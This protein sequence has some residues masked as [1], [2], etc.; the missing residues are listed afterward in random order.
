VICYNSTSN[1]VYC[2]NAGSQNLSVID[3]ATNTVVAT[4]PT[5]NVPRG[6]AF[7][8]QSDLVY[9]SNY[10]SDNVTVI[11]GATNAVVATV[12]VGDG[13]TALFHNPATNTMYCSNVGAPGP[14]TPAACT[15]SVIDATTNTV[16]ATLPAGD[17]PTAFC[18]STNN[19]KVYWVNEWSHTVAVVDAFTNAPITL[20][21]LGTPPVQA[22]DL[23]YNPVNERVYSANRLTYSIGI[24]ADSLLSTGAAE[25]DAA[26]LLVQ[27]YPNPASD[28][29]MI[30]GLVNG[31]LA[32]TVFGAHGA[33]LVQGTTTDRSI[34]VHQLPA[35]LH[36]L[37]LR[38]GSGQRCVE[39]VMV[40]R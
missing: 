23:C 27:L 30:T 10:G 20:I 32:Y 11:D 38:D 12:A 36:A 16:V 35:G 14:G 17:E 33:V 6:I 4:V 28:R 13:P 7:N 39:R 26:R 37:A 21:P 25:A 19:Q 9:C 40:E 5:G 34:P 2:P 15:I 24:I 22:V 3:G 31:P 1:K 8:P 29:V 18:Y